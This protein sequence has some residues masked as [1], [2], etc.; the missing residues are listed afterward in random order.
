MNNITNLISEFCLKHQ[1][2]TFIINDKE[3][4]LTYKEFEE[5]L[6]KAESFFEQKQLLKDINTFSVIAPNCLNYLLVLFT[7]LKH[8]KVAAN[9]NP[10]FHN[11]ELIDRL[12]SAHVDT[13]V[14]TYEYYEKLKDSLS[15]TNISKVIIIN[16]HS[17]KFEVLQIISLS[18]TSLT[19]E[20][21][22]CE[23]AFYQYTGGT[24][25]IVKAA[26]I[27][28]KNVINNIEQLNNHINKDLNINDIR[29]IIAF[30][31]Y[32]IFSVIFNVMYFMSIGGTCIL[33]SD[34]RNFDQIINLMIKNK[35][36]LSV[37]VNTWYNRLMLNSNFD[38][39]DFSN[40]KA[41][42][43]GGEYVPVSTK[44]KWREKTKVPIYSA[45]GLTETC[46]LTIIS[47]L[48]ENNK[49]DAL[50]IPV[51]GCEVI[52]LNNDN[53]IVSKGMV[54]EIS[55]KGGNII[56]Q[57]YNN[58]E[59][60]KQAFYNGWFKTG[61]LAIQVENEMYK[62]VDRKKDMISISGNKVY[63]NEIEEIIITLNEVVD[64]G[65]VGLKSDESGEEIAACIVTTMEDKK[66]LTKK[67]HAI[68]KEK[69]A[70]YKIPKHI[71]WYDILPKTPIGKTARNILR[72]EINK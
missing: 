65:V 34:L 12:S 33:N 72:K 63:P 3:E 44:T 37:G 41:A 19:V 60:T 69:L 13:L 8:K 30:P 25:G 15:L 36:N 46:S 64:I 51:P 6:I 50:G 53:E 47:P 28:H 7:F 49:D 52:L 29:I 71:F 23:A 5:E 31:F 54:G 11:L 14:T 38:K 39:I 4:K 68:C 22:N 45:Y 48:N 17:F 16:E 1:N 58:K 57:Y 35:V 70:S 42:F 27:T 24:S 32:H 43:A 67:I 56:K 66:E 21:T 40:F 61:D 9:L 26:V 55:L 20:K 59:E 62:L 2:K 18:E 10:N